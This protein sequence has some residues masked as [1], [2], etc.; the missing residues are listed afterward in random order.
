MYIPNDDTQNYPFYRLQLVVEKC[1]HY[2]GIPRTGGITVQDLFDLVY[3]LG[4]GP[5]IQEN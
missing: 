4:P 3:C 2:L 1:R 5:A